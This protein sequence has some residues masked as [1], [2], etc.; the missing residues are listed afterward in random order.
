MFE[1]SKFYCTL[2]IWFN[3][4]RLTK[5]VSMDC[6]MV[7]VGDGNENMLARVSVVNQH[8]EMVYDKFVKPME[9]VV[10]YRTHVSGV[11][12]EDMENG[13]ILLNWDK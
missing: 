8:G 6:E 7:G 11:R 9:K 3:N 12:R 4:F 10:D 5:V 2:K 13:L 1:P